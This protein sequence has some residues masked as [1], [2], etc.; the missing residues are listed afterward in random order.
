MEK[1]LN[2]KDLAEIIPFTAWSINKLCRDKAIP[3]YKMNG[4]CYFKLSQIKVWVEKK[5]QKMRRA[6]CPV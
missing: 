3:H 6:A 4:R 1:F 5:E 2:V